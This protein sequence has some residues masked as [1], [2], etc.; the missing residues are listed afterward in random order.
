MKLADRRGVSPEFLK[1]T[2]PLTEFN[3]RLA[4]FAVENETPTATDKNIAHIACIITNYL[5]RK[6]YKLSQFL[7]SIKSNKRQ[8]TKK[9]GSD[10]FKG[11]V[12]IVKKAKK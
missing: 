9:Q 7:P 4:Y 6:K 1:A 12:G 10:F 2:M 3:E 5:C 11:L 8:F